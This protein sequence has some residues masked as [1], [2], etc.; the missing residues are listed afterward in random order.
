MEA[1][2]LLVPVK[3][4]GLA[5]FLWVWSRWFKRLSHLSEREELRPDLDTLSKSWGEGC[6]AELVGDERIIGCNLERLAIELL[7]QVCV[8]GEALVYSL[9]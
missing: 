7:G 6:H 1:D 2:G 3:L 9:M 5:R 8:V 4:P